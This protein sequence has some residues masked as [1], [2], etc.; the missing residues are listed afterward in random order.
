M[1]TLFPARPHLLQGGDMRIVP[2]LVLAIV[3]LLAGGQQ[4]TR[5]QTDKPSAVS[6]STSAA[7]ADPWAVVSH[8]P[9]GELPKRRQSQHKREATEPL[10]ADAFTQLIA[11]G[12][13]MSLRE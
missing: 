5:Q 1:L 3:A 11:G 9:Q 12:K 8:V 13:P 10:T 7:A 6:P 4:K 2:T